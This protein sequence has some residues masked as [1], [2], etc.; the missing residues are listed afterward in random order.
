MT[1]RKVFAVAVLACV[2]QADLIEFASAQS[3]P[4]SPSGGGGG[5]NKGNRGGAGAPLPVMGATLLGQ[6]AGAGG[7]YVLWRRRRKDDV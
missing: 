1:L 7:I 4:T 6:L 2:W 5:S 3:R